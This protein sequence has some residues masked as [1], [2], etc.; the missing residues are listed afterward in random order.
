MITRFLMVLAMVLA[1]GQAVGQ[2]LQRVT[3]VRCETMNGSWEL[4]TGYLIGGRQCL[5]CVHGIRGNNV[6]VHWKGRWVSA[7]PV[8]VDFSSDWSML[9]LSEETGLEDVEIASAFPD[10]ESQVIAYGYGLP[11]DGLEFRKLR[12]IRGVVRPDCIESSSKPQPGDSGGPIF[13][14][15]GRLCGVISRGNKDGPKWWGFRNHN[16]RQFALGNRGYRL[17]MRGNR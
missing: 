8:A 13:D 11:S 15:R 3:E 2:D 17:Q 10:R 7:A 12:M 14:Q 4:G 6:Q 5:Y 1:A 16:L 9:E